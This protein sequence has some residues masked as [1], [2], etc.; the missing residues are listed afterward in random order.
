[1]GMEEIFKTMDDLFSGEGKPKRKQIR[2]PYTR[3]EVEAKL[4][5]HVQ[6]TAKQW[7]ADYIY[8]KWAREAK[9]KK[10]AQF[11]SGEVVQVYD[12]D[13]RENS[14]DF[15]RNFYSDGTTDTTCFGYSD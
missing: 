13:F 6:K 15:T 7:G 10:L 12:E 1:M 9:E 11:D 14:M 8:T 2:D 4:E 5:E 3:E